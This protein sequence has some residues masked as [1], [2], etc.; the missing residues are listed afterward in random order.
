MQ[1]T[2]KKSSLVNRAHI[3]DL[4]LTSQSITA[5]LAELAKGEVSSTLPEPALASMARILS[6]YLSRPIRT[7][8]EL[9]MSAESRALDIR[10]NSQSVTSFLRIKLHTDGGMF[11]INKSGLTDR[12]VEMLIGIAEGFANKE[13]AQFFKIGVRTVETHR[14][15]IMRKLD[16][17]TVAGLTRYAIA[18]G[19]I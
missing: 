19:L 7:T 1:P 9:E 8:K 18:S 4:A 14:E 16:I 17:H 15:R 12:E 3:P 5:A 10:N 6:E 11:D 13:L 2:T